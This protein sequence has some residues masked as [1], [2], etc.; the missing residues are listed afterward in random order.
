MSYV[1]DIAEILD[2]MQADT[3]VPRNI[4]LKLTTVQIILTGHEESQI[5]ISRAM[6]ELDDVTDDVNMQPYT[7]TQ[8][9]SLVS[10]LEQMGNN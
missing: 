5:K 1:D 8:I 4:K 10:L 2:E 7:R 6:Q 3:T 9:Y